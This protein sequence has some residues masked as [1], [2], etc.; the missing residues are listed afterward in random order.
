MG[1]A[2]LK[3]SGNPE[4]YISMFLKLSVM[5]PDLSTTRRFYMFIDGLDEPLHG[6]LSLT[7]PLPYKIP[8]KGL[9]IYKMPCQ[10]KRQ[11]FSES[12]LFHPREKMRR[13]LFQR[14]KIKKSVDDDV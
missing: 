7:S 1:L 4:T 11:N 13:L 12:P 2:K 10:N 3:Q 6:W 5:V 9:E 8:F 14:A